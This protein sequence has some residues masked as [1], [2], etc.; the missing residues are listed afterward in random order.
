MSLRATHVRPSAGRRLVVALIAAAL[1]LASATLRPEPA[2]AQ[3]VSFSEKGVSADAF[4]EDCTTEDELSTCTVTELFAFEGKQTSSE[5]GSFKGTR[6]CLFLETF[7]FDDEG[8]F[9][10]ESGCST[11]PAGTLTVARGLAS[12]MLQPTTVRLDTYECTFDETTG[13]EICVI[14]S[15]REVTVSASWT[16][17]GPLARFSE[18]F[19]FRVDKC[20]ETFSAKGESRD[21]VATATLDG[22][23]LGESDF[24]SIR[25]GKFDFR[26]TCPIE[27]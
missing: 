14:V 15:S 27:P 17:T 23:A 8:P 2:A 1:I 10:F 4:W 3:A 25:T 18:R 26:S 21:A 9:S 12:A 19:R 5:T 16:A 24:A 13:E 11:A 22:A 20:T 7:S 6:V